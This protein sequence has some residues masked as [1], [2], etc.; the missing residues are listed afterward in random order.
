M[1]TEESVV[2]D[3]ATDEESFDSGGEGSRKKILLWNLY[4]LWVF[5]KLG[6]ISLFFSS[7]VLLS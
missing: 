6:F 4:Y 7:K 5:L 1:R 2:D 3:G